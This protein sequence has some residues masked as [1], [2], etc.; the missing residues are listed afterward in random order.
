MVTRESLKG[1]K[2]G[3]KRV[4]LRLTLGISIAGIPT[5]TPHTPIS[6]TCTTYQRVWGQGFVIMGYI[7]RDIPFLRYSGLQILT[8]LESNCEKTSGHLRDFVYVWIRTDNMR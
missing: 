6:S 7:E 4:P 5:P 2:W 8:Y 1:F 3:E